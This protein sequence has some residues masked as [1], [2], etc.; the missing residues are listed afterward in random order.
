MKENKAVNLET[1]HTHTH[2]SNLK[3]KGITLIAL[4]ITIIILLILAGITIVGLK[5]NGL[6]GKTEI[7]K[8]KTRYA[9]AKETVNL[10]LME[11]QVECTDKGEDYNI[12]KIAEGMK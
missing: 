7:A 6:F 11:I 3:N 1:V 10:K 8:Q 2:T 12:K 4:V 5:G 9:A